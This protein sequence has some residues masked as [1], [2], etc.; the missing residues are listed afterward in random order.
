MWSTR[1]SYKILIKLGFSRQIFEKSVNI[2]EFHQNPSSG[3][4]NLKVTSANR[5]GATQIRGSAM[6][7]F[8]TLRNHNLRLRIT[9]LWRNIHTKFRKN[10][11]IF[12]NLKKK[13]KQPC[14]NIIVTQKV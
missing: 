5:D 7:F 9:V 10:W 12:Q 6:L 11:Y 1:Y 3:I 14:I 13:D 4:H 2:Q 8:R